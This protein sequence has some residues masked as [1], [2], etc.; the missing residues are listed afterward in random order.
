[1][2]GW[3]RPNRLVHSPLTRHMLLLGVMSV[4]VLDGPAVQNVRRRLSSGENANPAVAL[5]SLNQSFDACHA[6][7]V[8]PNTKRPSD[9]ELALGRPASRPYV[10][11]RLLFDAT[12]LCWICMRITRP[13]E[14]RNWFGKTADRGKQGKVVCQR[15]ETHGCT[16]N[17]AFPAVSYVLC[18]AFV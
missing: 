4:I 15:L 10:G 13:I 1:M 5:S 2:F 11:L 16:A 14:H 18:Y 6:M 17:H 3:I 9:R 12:R 7:R 8:I